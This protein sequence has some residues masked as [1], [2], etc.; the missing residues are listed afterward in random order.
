MRYTITLTVDSD[1]EEEVDGFAAF[2][3]DPM[4]AH[5][6]EVQGYE[7]QPAPKPNTHLVDTY[8]GL[9][10][11]ELYVDDCEDD[12]TGHCAVCCGPLS[13]AEVMQA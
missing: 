6:V 3:A 2:I 8:G 5:D 10:P 11:V 4:T 9:A 1:S 13:E 7:V 12:G